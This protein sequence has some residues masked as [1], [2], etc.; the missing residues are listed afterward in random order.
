MSDVIEGTATELPPEEAKPAGPGIPDAPQDI[1][2][3]E[4]PLDAVVVVKSVD[5][6]GTISTDVV[7]NGNVQATEVA[8][9]LEM[10]L[11]SWRK[12]IGLDK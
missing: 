1:P 8:T 6:N 4:A 7:I 9:L 12:K 10:A 3:P 2:E 5:D 11:P